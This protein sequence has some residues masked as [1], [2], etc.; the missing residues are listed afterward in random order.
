MYVKMDGKL[1]AIK[2]IK[3]MSDSKTSLLHTETETGTEV[4]YKCPSESPNYYHLGKLS[5][6][7][8]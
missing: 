8:I 6:S 5:S 2:R 7:D 4:V 1:E 3:L